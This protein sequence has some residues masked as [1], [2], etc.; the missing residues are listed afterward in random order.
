MK[1][2]AELKCQVNPKDI[3]ISLLAIA[4]DQY[5]LWIAIPEAT[6]NL[7]A[8]HTRAHAAKV[9]CDIFIPTILSPGLQPHIRFKILERGLTNPLEIKKAA[10]T[11]KLLDNE[12]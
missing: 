12:K 6:R 2:L 8:A 10:I 9:A 1:I 4:D 3:E 7:I 11:I 5:A